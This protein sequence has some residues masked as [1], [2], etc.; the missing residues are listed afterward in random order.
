MRLDDLPY[1]RQTE[2][3]AARFPSRR[4]I[5]L[6]E[7]LEDLLDASRRDANAGVANTHHDQIGAFFL[8]AQHNPSTGRCELDGILEQLVECPV[9]LFR[10]ALYEW[11]ILR[12]DEPEIQALIPGLG[13]QVP[14][15]AFG[16]PPD[17]HG[18]LSRAHFA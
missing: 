2:A 1:K 15:Q 3:G 8:Q 11:E 4:R 5:E 10:I 9:D 16:G 13:C 6:M 17:I 18:D 14:H 12:R 7:W